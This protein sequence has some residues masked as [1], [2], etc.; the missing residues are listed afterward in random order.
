VTDLWVIPSELNHG[1]LDPLANESRGPWLNR[2][3]VD[4]YSQRIG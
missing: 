4:F 3:V 1:P 2:S